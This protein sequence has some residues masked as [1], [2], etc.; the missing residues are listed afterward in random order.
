MGD[1][2]KVT[3][4]THTSAI[5]IDIMKVFQQFSSWYLLKKFVAWMLRFKGRLRR[6]VAK[7]KQGQELQ[8]PKEMKISPIDVDELRDAERAIIKLVQSQT[9]KEELLSL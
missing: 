5:S 8:F 7:R 2:I 1:K 4:A 3:F 6:A 9:F